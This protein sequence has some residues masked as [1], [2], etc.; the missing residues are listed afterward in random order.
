MTDWDVDSRV[1][2]SSFPDVEWSG[3]RTGAFSANT[4]FFSRWMGFG[5]GFLHF[6]DV[7]GSPADM[8]ARTLYGRKFYQFVLE[9]LGYEDIPGRK[10]A[11]NVN[12]SL[13]RWLDANR[14][15]P[16]FCFVNY[17]DAHD[18][19][20]PPEPYRSKF[21][22]RKSPGGA[23]NSFIL[24]LDLERPDQLQGEIDAYDGA[25]AYLDDEIGRLLAAL[26]ERGLAGNTLVAI[27]S[28]H[29][30]SFGEHGLLL[31]RNALY[32]EVVRV[33]LLI[34]WPGHLPQGAKVV[35]PV[36]IASLPSTIL[37]LLG[38]AGQTA[39]PGPSLA[40]LWKE[41]APPAAWPYPLAEL[42]QFRFGRVRKNPAYSGAMK[43]LITPQWQWIRHERL[44]TSLY[45]WPHDSREENDLAGTPQGHAVTQS[46]QKCI[47]ANP[48]LLRQPNC[49]EQP[50]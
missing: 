35:A 26:E 32:L 13:L 41:A 25:I 48:A 17:F 43:S 34:I 33:P 2:R 10:H 20:L 45:D 14:A 49:G 38:D 1:F 44:G 9:R 28:D 31:H 4:V 42:A 22:N 50:K 19:Y 11:R 18:P 37:D 46:L 24:R 15:R 39:F 6:E 29:G 8:A 5:P 7:F 47:E 12:R 23:L 21:S 36:S 27:V 40:S 30:E 3:F 16:F